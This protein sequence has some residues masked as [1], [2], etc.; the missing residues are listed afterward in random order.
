[1]SCQV[2]ASIVPLE[3]FNLKSHKWLHRHQISYM[4]KAK[5]KHG[6][7]AEQKPKA[8]LNW[9]SCSLPLVIATST[10]YGIKE[11]LLKIPHE[12]KK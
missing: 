2:K 11:C 6:V 1:M 9:V 4:N 5:Q 12:I 10:F 3:T 8:G 7:L